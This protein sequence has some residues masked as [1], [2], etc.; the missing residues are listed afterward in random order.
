VP[1]L[2]DCAEG[3]SANSIVVHKCSQVFMVSRNQLTLPGAPGIFTDNLKS[4]VSGGIGWFAHTYSDNQEPGYGIYNSMKSE[5]PICTQNRVLIDVCKPF[6][7]GLKYVYSI[8]LFYPCSMSQQLLNCITILWISAN[9]NHMN[10]RAD[11]PLSHKVSIYSYGPANRIP[12]PNKTLPI[13]IL[14]YSRSHSQKKKST[15]IIEL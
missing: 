11:G 10:F 8:S 5:V 9:W 1:W 13:Q 7:C 12:P 4:I 3:P 14:I 6:F 15:I 2:W